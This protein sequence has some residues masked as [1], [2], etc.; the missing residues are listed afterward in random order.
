[1]ANHND[2][3]TSHFR[4]RKVGRVTPCAPFGIFLNAARTE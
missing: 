4:G 2:I 3:G 1:M